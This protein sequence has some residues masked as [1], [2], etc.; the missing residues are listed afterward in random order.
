MKIA[1]GLAVLGT[2][3]VLVAHTSWAADSASVTGKVMLEGAAPKGKKI[4]MDADPVCAGMHPDT[5]RS[6]EVVANDNGT[7][8]NV[9]VYVKSGLEG[10]TY[11]A[12][13]EPVVLNQKGCLYEPH[14]FGM[15]AKQ[16][17]KIVN[18]DGTLHNIHAMPEKSKEF[19]VGQP[20]QG[21]E[22][23][24][25]FANPEVM[26]KFKC[27]VHPWMGAYVGV[28]DHPFY[29]VTGEDGSFTLKG[30]PAGKYVVEAWHEKLGSQTQT[31]EVADGASKTVSFTFKAEKPE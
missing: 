14:V 16:P 7:L 11:D 31:V 30:L 28:L 22:T 29:A 4:K 5:V 9:F 17:L 18:S 19:N 27:D 2:A 6:P 15:Q 20:N 3:V 13:K 25:T 12:P 23:T 10:H 8:R 26:V 1:S 24:R 21:M